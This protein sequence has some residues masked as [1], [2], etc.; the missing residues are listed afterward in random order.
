MTVTAK[1]L[2]NGSQLTGAAATY[3]T[4]PASTK[5]VVKSCAICNTT[6]G[7]IAVTVY[8][9]PSGGTAGVTNAVISGLSVAANATY[10]CPELVNQVIEA[11]GTLQALGA[12]LTIVASGME[13]TS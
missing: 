4:A 3:Y 10:A 11:A 9:V 13:L 6:A 1:R 5:A 12:N 2:V 8:L 7:A